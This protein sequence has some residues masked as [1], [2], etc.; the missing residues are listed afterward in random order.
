MDNT[1]LFNSRFFKN[2][3][4]YDNAFY[5]ITYFLRITFGNY[6]TFINQHKQQLVVHFNT[7]IKYFELENPDEVNDKGK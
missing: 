4:L 7:E 6:V 2:T 3:T 5:A 1:N